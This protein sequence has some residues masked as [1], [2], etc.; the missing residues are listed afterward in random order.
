MKAFYEKDFGSYWFETGTPTFLVKKLKDTIFDVRKFTDR[1]LYASESMLKDYTG[2]SLDPVPLLYQTGYLTIADFERVG[3]EYTLVFPNE[4]VKYGF[5]ECLMPEYV[6]D[7]VAGSDS[8]L[9]CVY[10]AEEVRPM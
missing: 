1:T 5:V 10:T 4:E 7:C 6:A 2:D 8:N 9:P 3:R